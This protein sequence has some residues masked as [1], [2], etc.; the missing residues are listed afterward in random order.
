MKLDGTQLTHRPYKHYSGVLKQQG[1]VDLDADW[2]EYVDIQR[3]LGQTQTKDVIGPR[4]APKKG[5][6]FKID[7]TPKGEDLTIS[8]GRIYVGGVLCELEAT[9]VPVDKTNNARVVRV[10]NLVVDGRR[11]EDKQWV[12]LLTEG[13]TDTELTQIEDVNPEEKKLTLDSEVSDSVTH[14][15]R[16]TTYT[17]QPDYPDPDLPGTGSAERGLYLLYLDV[18]QRHISALED[19][20]IREVALGGPDTATRAK[21]VWQVKYEKIEDPEGVECRNFGY[22]WTPGGTSTPPVMAA[23]AE[24]ELPNEALCDFPPGAG[25][26]GL[27]NRLYRVEVHDAG[28]PYGWPRPSSVTSTSVTIVDDHTIKVPPLGWELDGRIW[29]TGQVVELFSNDTN[30]AQRAGTLAIITRVSESDKQLTLD[31]DVSNMRAQSGLE[32]RRVATFKWSRDN[33]SVAFSVDEFITDKQL[34]VKRRGRDQ[35]LGLHSDDWVEVL[36]DAT[37]LSGAPGTLA[38]IT[39]EELDESERKISLS[40][41]VSAHEGEDHPKVHRWDSNGALAVEVPANGD[42]WLGIE[43]GVQVKF[44]LDSIYEPGDYWLIPARTA[45]NDVLWPRNEPTR[46]PLFEVRHGTVHHYCA[47]ALVELRDEG[48]VSRQDCRPLFP[49]LTEI[50][51]G[52]CCV[53]V[54]PGERVQQAID[55]V[56]RAGGGCVC[57]GTGVH[58]VTEPLRLRNARNLTLEGESLSSV[59][60]MD[61]TDGQAGLVLESCAHVS[62][63]GIFVVGKNVP[64]LVDVRAEPEPS[65]AVALRN[66]TMLNDTRSTPEEPGATC[67]VRLADVDGVHM[68]DCRLL[69][70]VGVLC[71][72]GDRLPREFGGLEERFGSR[73]QRTIGLED[74]QAGREFRVGEA[75]IVPGVE[76]TALRFVD[77]DDGE[78][79]VEES[80]SVVEVEEVAEMEVNNASLGFN[81]ETPAPMLSLGFEHSTGDLSLRINDEPQSVIGDLSEIDGQTIGGV[82]ITVEPEG[83]IGAT[84]GKLTLTGAID[85]FVIGGPQVRIRAVSFIQ[86]SVATVS[87]G[88]RDLHMRGVQVRYLTFGAWAVTAENWLLEHCDFRSLGLLRQEMPPGEAPPGF[89]EGDGAAEPDVVAAHPEASARWGFPGN[90]LEDGS[91]AI[92]ARLLLQRVDETFSRKVEILTGVAVRAFLWRDCTVHAT[93]LQGAYGLFAWWWLGGAATDTT[94]RAFVRGIF[95]AWVHEARWNGNRLQVDLA[96]MAFVG[97]YRTRIEDNHVRAATGLTNVPL[98]EVAGELSS[99]LEEV[100]RNYAAP[101]NDASA[102]AVLW[103]LLEESVRILGLSDLKQKAQVVI[104]ATN[105]RGIPVLALAARALHAVLNKFEERSDGKSAVPAPIVALSVAGNDIEGTEHSV[106]LDDFVPLGGVRVAEN[107][108]HTVTGQALKLDASPYAVNV[109]VSIALWRA[110]SQQLGRVAEDLI[111]GVESSDELSDELEA[112]LRGLLEHL[113]YLLEDWSTRSESFLEANLTVEQNTIH[114]LYTAIESNLFELTIRDNQITLQEQPVPNRDTAMVISRLAESDTLRPLAVTMRAGMST[115]VARFG[116]AALGDETLLEDA[117]VRADMAEVS[118]SIGSSVSDPG[119]TDA[120]ISLGDAFA[121]RNMAAVLERVRPFVEILEGTTNTHGIW[122]K[123]PGARIIGNQIRV[124]TDT[125]PDTWARGGILLWTDR[126]SPESLVPINMLQRMR[127]ELEV[128]DEPLKLMSGTENLID[129]NEIIGGAGHGISIRKTILEVPEPL[130]PLEQK[131][132][133]FEDLALDRRFGVGDTF[134]ASG[135]NI[136]PQPF[137]SSGGETIEG[138]AVVIARESD[139]GTDKAME[140]HNIS[141]GFDLGSSVVHNLSLRFRYSRG[142]LNIGINDKLKKVRVL[143]EVHDQTIGGVAVSVATEGEPGD[144]HWTLTLSGAITSFTIGGQEP[145]LAAAFI[146]PL[147]IDDVSFSQEPNIAYGMFDLKVR[148]NQVRGMAG[149]GILLDEEAL[150]VGVDINDN[151]VTGCSGLAALATL[152]DVKGG[153][154]IRNATLCR[155]HGNRI[156]RCGNVGEEQGPPVFAIEIDSIFDLTLANNHVL[157]NRPHGAVLLQEVFG[158]TGIRDNDILLD[159]GVN[160]RTAPVGIRAANLEVTQKEAPLPGPLVSLL[161]V[162]FRL[163]GDASLFVPS[164]EVHAIFLGNRLRQVQPGFTAPLNIYGLSH[165]SFTGNHISC[166]AGVWTIGTVTPL[167]LIEAPALIGFLREGVVANNLL[168]GRVRFSVDGMGRGVVSGNVSPTPIWL[169]NSGP[170]VK[171]GL[172]APDVIRLP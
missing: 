120:S 105:L 26:R 80:I 64:A 139:D 12:E 100:A 107:R 29:Q 83:E 6:G 93:H 97:G 77:R 1:R 136:T 17:T 84:R 18:W 162:Y 16:I 4:G 170:T 79:P 68:E 59:L 47:L 25:Y 90:M 108:L 149:A 22:D 117:E 157:Q 38:R 63:E 99:Y 65:H 85:S 31:K 172:N 28:K 94:I 126:D 132:I 103:V 153:L 24:P 137:Q 56:I 111:S 106:S 135:V 131:T 128:N 95:A 101:S 20:D 164:N 34:K 57:L 110:I 42:G 51:A 87:P 11:F 168:D 13:S 66:L 146:P 118:A 145:P 96:A 21:T 148:A 49:H 115:D 8:P 169:R 122:L 158:S 70:E 119:L 74:V 67:A 44:D 102:L 166:Q 30:A 23:R 82:A 171:D 73:G 7:A 161:D 41:D 134:G 138:S 71:L 88:V 72:D 151:H 14:L 54:A 140:L 19:P 52:G 143:G 27:E 62:M 48:W 78:P 5:G 150:I 124:P 60:L 147:S 46:A 112:A 50:E 116:V 43:D 155:V 114:S 75:F 3:H 121:R 130:G 127:R 9:P 76:V 123:G 33:G 32:I 53:H 142:E 58:R 10:Q 165:L 113:A 98:L 104:D 45:R 154:V 91:S 141:L 15:R 92:D 129:G 61:G 152:T 86:D 36:G 109:R 159:G 35:V 37:E 125:D 144:L 40:E 163:R 2:N 81:F 167:I 39:P 69:A 133:D 55:T 160:P 89:S 156:S